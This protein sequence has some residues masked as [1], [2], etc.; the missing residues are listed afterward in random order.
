MESI[1]VAGGW[2]F[3]HRIKPIMDELKSK[4]YQ[5]NSGWIDRENRI[6]TP[7]DYGRCAYLDTEEVRASDILLAIMDDDSYAYR[8]TWLEIGCAIG[9]DKKV[10]LLCPGTTTNTS[11]GEYDHSYYCIR[12]VFF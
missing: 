7:E 3:R 2:P 6:N 10:V 12:N 5:I 11:D 4:G 8:G 1:Y 9:L